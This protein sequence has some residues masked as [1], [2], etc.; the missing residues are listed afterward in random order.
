V[1]ACRAIGPTVLHEPEIASM[2][3]SFLPAPDPWPT[4]IFSLRLGAGEIGEISWSTSD[5]R[6][7]LALALAESAVDPKE[8]SRFLRAL[9]RTC[10]K[11]SDDAMLKTVL[12]AVR[13]LGRQ[14][15]IAPEEILPFLTVEVREMPCFP[16]VAVEGFK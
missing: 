9:L 5:G 2:L 4:W 16:T 12:R 7:E 6:G 1:D 11:S 8:T 10:E 13:T 3:Q 15:E 14:G